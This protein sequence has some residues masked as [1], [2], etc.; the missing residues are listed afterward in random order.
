MC[1]YCERR[2]NLSKV[3]KIAAETNA[4]ARKLVQEFNK[5]LG[6]LREPGWYKENKENENSSS[7]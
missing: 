2:I 5:K 1:P 6:E 3:E 7:K 4:Q